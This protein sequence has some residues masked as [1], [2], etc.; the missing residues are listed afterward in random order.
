MKSTNDAEKKQRTPLPDLIH[1]PVT[2]RLMIVIP[3][4]MCVIGL[5]LLSVAPVRYDLKVGDT[6]QV[7][8][9][10]TKEIVDQMSTDRARAAAAAA[11][12]PAYIPQEGAADEA[13]EDLDRI[14]EQISKIQQYAETMLE[15]NSPT[16]VYS[17]DELSFARD[18]CTELSLSNLQLT[19]VMHATAEDIEKLHQRLKNNVNRVMSFYQISESNLTSQINYILE[20]TDDVS[21][22]LFVRLGK[23]ILLKCVRPNV[24]IDEENWQAAK[25]EAMEKVPPVVYRQGQNI[26]EQG[27]SA[28]TEEQL[29]VLSELGLLRE[30]IA[31]HK[32]YIG[33]VLL[34]CAVMVCA[35]MFLMRTGREIYLSTR[36]V[37][38]V[39]IVFVFSF[40]ICLPLRLVNASL[41]PSLLCALLLTSMVSMRCGIILNTT[42]CLLV[43]FLSAG[44]SEEYGM[45]MLL[46]LVCGIISGCV[47]CLLM[48]KSTSRVRA[49]IV[50]PIAIALNSLICVSIGMLTSSDL[51]NNLYSALWMAGG[52]LISV[53]LYFVLQ[54]ILEQIFNLPTPLK[55]LELSNPTH[56]LLRRLML[57]APG[58]YHHSVIVANLAEASAE[59]IGADPLLARVGAYYHDIGKL[60]RPDFFKE[61]QQGDNNVH[62][63]TDPQ[64]SAAILTAHI[65]DGAVMARE[66]RLPQAVQQIVAT[67]HGDAPV[68]YFYHK[69]LQQA[70]GKPVDIDNF[71]YDSEPPS[72]REASIIMLCDT[73]EAAVRSMKN[74]E[75]DAVEEFIVR[76]IRGKLEDGQLSN[77]PLTLQDIDRISQACI[78]VL[79]GVYHERIQYPTMPVTHR[80]KIRK[81][82]ESS[83]AE[84][85]DPDESSRAVSSESSGET[86]LPT[87]EKAETP[88][89]V[90][91]LS[92]ASEKAPF[93][94]QEAS[95]S[96][97]TDG[98]SDS[99]SVS[100]ANNENNEINDP[101][102]PAD[103]SLSHETENNSLEPFGADTPD[104]SVSSETETETVPSDQK[105]QRE[106]EETN[107]PPAPEIKDAGP[108]LV[109]EPSPMT[110]IPRVEVPVT[111]DKSMLLDELLQ[112]MS[113][114]EES[115][116]STDESHV[117]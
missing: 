114:P 91:S 100:P 35:C 14:F 59:A 45:T 29:A 75:Q 73:I 78:T 116:S 111:N 105:D 6:P 15:N 76:L 80:I 42:Q 38:L 110:G 54:L 12:I 82:S 87:E 46:T 52:T 48:R 79:S 41:V 85:N 74:H 115:G 81:K 98:G 25:N 112:S 96:S 107:V 37:L 84:S 63:H 104:S 83:F 89:I 93:S 22:T 17:A 16:R 13:M 47:T 61:N 102:P 40:G 34:V 69:A 21:T 113:K 56:P 66:Y 101:E 7:T 86:P 88:P 53:L 2:V 99:I 65:K 4:V 8:I 60:M 39:S 67:H 33:S 3:A 50:A 109:V 27:G 31:D 19:T 106:N 95:S 108:V 5:F 23:P 71:R 28:I 43:S 36:H 64:V 103:S 1:S 68:M 26:L 92:D 62:D 10:A 57:E 30:G 20:I 44:S 77:S 51:R 58:T 9:R 72:T 90:P 94:R 49:L 55:L 11:V 117:S 18:L 70:D 97:L 24:I 32:L